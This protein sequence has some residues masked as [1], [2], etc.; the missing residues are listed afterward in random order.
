MSI[1]NTGEPHFKSVIGPPEPEPES[2]PY[3]D[4][5]VV[6]VVKD[7]EV[8]KVVEVVK[9]V[10]ILFDTDISNRRERTIAIL[11]HLNNSLCGPDDGVLS[12]EIL[13]VLES[14]F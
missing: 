5:G 14:I 6:E 4:G 12:V 3:P 11:D 8:V 9:D 13:R 1:L 7:V 10:E 2:E